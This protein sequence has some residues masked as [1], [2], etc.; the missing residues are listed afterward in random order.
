M[1]MTHLAIAGA[2]FI[3]LS[4]VLMARRP[5]AAAPVADPDQARIE[6]EFQAIAAFHGRA[7]STHAGCVTLWVAAADLAQVMRTEDV[8]VSSP[9]PGNGYYVTVRKASAAW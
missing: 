3:L 6:A 1:T 5:K 9:A 2:C 7:G 4:L 8:L